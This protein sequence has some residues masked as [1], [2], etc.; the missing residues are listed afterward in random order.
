METTRPKDDELGL[1]AFLRGVRSAVRELKP[2]DRLTVTEWA[3]RNRMLS[4]KTAAAGPYRVDRAPYQREPQDVF[5]D[6]SVV[7]LTL[8]WGAQSGKTD[9]VE[10]NILGYVIDHDPQAVI[11]MH[12]TQD[13]ARDWSRQK[14][15]PMIAESPC[16]AEK[17]APPRSRD[18]SS[19]IL[20]K[21]YAGGFVLAIAGN[22]PRQTRGRSAPIVIE[23]ECDGI[24]P[25]PEGDPGELLWRR[26][27]TFPKKKRV[28][29]STPTIKGQSRIEAAFEDSDKR[30]YFVPC[31]DCGL[32]QK[33]VWKQVKW[34]QDG[35]GEHDPST[36]HYECE[37]CGF[38]IEDRHK[39]AMLRGGEWIAEKPFKGHA[40]FHLNAIYS[41]WTT[42]AEL[43]SNF[44]RAKRNHDLQTF[45][46]TDLAETWAEDG[47]S[48]PDDDLYERRYDW[49]LGLPKGAE[50]PEGVAFLTLSA[51]VQRQPP[52]VE[53]EVQGWGSGQERWSIE[54]G[55]IFGD[56][57]GDPNVLKDLDAILD[58]PFWHAKGIQ[59]YVRAAGI[60]SGGHATQ[61]IY[62]YCKPRFRRPLPD[63]RSQFVFALK[64]RSEASGLRRPIWPDKIS[65]SKV[66]PRHNFFTIGVDA[67][68]DRLHSRLRITE[69]GPG[70]Y[71]FPHD[72]D[73]DFFKGLVSETREI[74]YHVG[75]PYSVWRPKRK[76]EPTEPLDLAVY[77]IAV[78]E[79]IQSDPFDLD[80]EAEA[81]KIATLVPR[82]IPT[83]GDA[84]V[85]AA[86]KPVKRGTRRRQTRSRGY[87][88]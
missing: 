48:I 52:R 30:Y 84:Q 22:A 8:M 63:G 6:P 78:L 71:H 4:S 46:N 42:F 18:K 88:A 16:L 65:E 40:G 53:Y 12:P 50:L 60:D 15:E 54:Y 31:P 86:T 29:T 5:A 28:R 9:G 38:R 14:L 64:G 32:M 45:V 36:A 68:K 55:R 49:T 66:L 17:V 3:E 69:P 39:M 67:C 81:L 44:L 20:R 51:D 47:E 11:F 87:E 79:G 83:A 21:E 10:G 59:L 37:G 34:E 70:Y 7:E 80:L 77:G 43:A 2:P 1:A 35:E 27:R 24:K 75:K 62:K 25:G 74:R 72:R 82:P 23:D 13:D 33:L 41:P 26:A 56:V 19:T 73:R 85:V 58:R 61:T 76:H 57:D